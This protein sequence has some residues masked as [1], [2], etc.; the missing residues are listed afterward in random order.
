M[1]LTA[2]LAATCV[3][4]VGAAGAT[5]IKLRQLNRAYSDLPSTLS[6]LQTQVGES[7]RLLD[8]LLEQLDRDQPAFQHPKDIEALDLHSRAVSFII[9]DIQDHVAILDQAKSSSPGTW[10]SVQDGWREDGIAQS[11]LRL[12]RQLE[13]L[14]VYTAV[15]RPENAAQDLVNV[16][17]PGDKA[18]LLTAWDDAT[19]YLSA[20]TQS[21]ANDLPS[22]THGQPAG[23]EAESSSTPI[24]P[25][26]QSERSL[27]SPRPHL[28]SPEYAP[29]S[30]SYGSGS[31]PG[32]ST[33][34]TVSS[35]STPQSQ[36]Q[37]LS[38]W[39]KPGSIF[40]PS[41]PYSAQVAYSL[42]NINKL[43][44]QK[45]TY[46]LDSL[47]NQ[48]TSIPTPRKIKSMALL[49][50]P[51]QQTE[52]VHDLAGQ[53][54]EL[55]PA[56]FKS[57]V[58]E[59]SRGVSPMWVLRTVPAKSKGTKQR[60]CNQL[61]RNPDDNI[62]PDKLLGQ[63]KVIEK[64]LWNAILHKEG[65]K[66]AKIMQHRWSDN[67]VVEKRDRLTALHV[68]ASLGLCSIVHSLVS[69]GANPNVPDKFGASP[70][71]HAAEFGCPSCIALLVSAGAKPDL[72]SPRTRIQTPIYYAARR[73]KTEAVQALLDVGAHVY[74]A[75][76]NPRETNLYAAV[77]SG[78]LETCAVLLN[79]GA[80]A[81]E[82]YELLALAIS[83]SPAVL[84]LLVKAGADIDIRNASNQRTLL[85]HYIQEGDAN[86]VSYLLSLGA[87]P[88]LAASGSE[89]AALHLA[90]GKGGHPNSATLVRLLLSA[91]DRI[92]A[93]NNLGQ[94]PL[95]LAVLWGKAEAAEILCKAGAN[96]HLPD[97]K[98]SS[99]LSEVRTPGYEQRVASGGFKDFP[100]TR[101]VL[102]RWHS[103]FIHGAPAVPEM[104]GQGTVLF[105]HAERPVELPNVP[106]HVQRAELP[107][108]PKHLQRVEL[109]GAPKRTQ[110]PAEL[111]NAPKFMAELDSTPIGSQELPA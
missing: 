8:V 90:L 100:G 65:E 44:I 77:E 58:S 29:S 9:K 102:E 76:P 106:K 6:S 71:H 91:G 85:S 24:S 61:T 105:G 28:Q 73:G 81:R 16:T 35:L 104:E 108:I 15:S 78:S 62:A 67:I 52:V 3:E 4:L 66:V 48:K 79:R 39:S 12:R 26:Q 7:K 37:S 43:A 96:I 50:K 33:I 87:Q 49:Q 57:R 63:F 41:G 89:G 94:T 53:G 74:T 92:N 32:S 10:A 42:N 23:Y 70:L 68:A 55:Y 40:A 99:P 97:S 34:P 20:S 17:D 1:D 95:H 27:N 46:W 59:Y 56:E 93:Q 38:P 21:T 98:G 54:D 13:A 64:D 111:P 18:S 22:P 19:S 72:D 60:Y 84:G 25:I 101:S 30:I 14:R 51:S 47:K 75:V 69:V 82:G 110:G 80:N 11:E 86:M 109:P 83:T 103:R 5:S 45:S 36:S 107:N 31:T 2:D 88:A